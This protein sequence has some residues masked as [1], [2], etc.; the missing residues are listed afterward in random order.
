MSNAKDRN[1]HLA[2]KTPNRKSGEHEPVI[3]ADLRMKRKK[4]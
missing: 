2:L 3:P 4:A 1:P